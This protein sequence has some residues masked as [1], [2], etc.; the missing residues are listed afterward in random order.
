[1]SLEKNKE[2][3]W[4]WSDDGPAALSAA[5]AKA[6]VP[7][8]VKLTPVRAAGVPPAL[9]SLLRWSCL[10]LPCPRAP[11]S[12][13]WLLAGPGGGAGTWVSVHRR[14]THPCHTSHAADGSC[15]LCRQGSSSGR[16][17]RSSAAAGTN[18]ATG[19]LFLLVAKVSCDCGAC[20]SLCASAAGKVPEGTARGHSG[21]PP[22]A[23][24][25][26]RSL[27]LVLSMLLCRV[28]PAQRKPQELLSF[29]LLS[30]CSQVMAARGWPQLTFW[31]EPEHKVHQSLLVGILRDEE[32]L[33]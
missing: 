1:M 4:E 27:M 21:Q 13:S 28:I 10:C 6:L 12:P 14:V 7:Q 22:A 17:L 30:W 19:L 29:A 9:E 26:V 24:A 23:E 33:M 3:R 18:C 11:L 8:W 20:I 16:R 31:W 32:M 2:R 25:L 15:S 5:G